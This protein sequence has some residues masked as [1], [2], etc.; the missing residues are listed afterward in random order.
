METVRAASDE[1]REIHLKDYLGVMRKHVWVLLAFFTITEGLAAFYVSRQVP[2]YRASARIQIDRES[3]RVL[4]IPEVVEPDRGFYGDEYYQTQYQ[5]LRSRSLVLEVARRLGL[6]RDPDFLA[7][8]AAGAADAGRA[9]ATVTSGEAAETMLINRM[10]GMVSIDPIKNTRLVDIT[11][12]STKPSTAA[13]VSNAMA[14]AFIERNQELRLNTTRQAT[15]WLGTQLEDARKKVEESETALQR[16][17]EE[18]DI[19]SPEKNVNL[20]GQKLEELSTALTKAKTDRIALETRY[21]Q[22][23]RMGSTQEMLDSLP[24]V[25]GNQLI[26]QMKREYAQLQGELSTLSKTYTPK[27]PKIISLRSQIESLESR[28]RA[29]VAKVTASIRNE[30]EVAKAREESIQEAVDQQKQ[31]AQGLSQKSIQLGA[32][33]REVENNRRIYGILLNRAKE[34]GLAEGIQAGNIRIIDRAEVPLAPFSPRR[35]R[36]MALAVLFGLLGGVALAFFLE[37][38]DDSI[39][40]PDDLERYTRLPFLAPVPIIRTRDKSTP[41]ELVAHKEPKSS[42]AEAYRSARTG[43]MFSSPDAPPVAILVTSSGPEEGKTTTAINLAVTMAHAG[44]RVLVLD[45]D[46]RKPRVHQVFGLKNG[47]GLTNLLTESTDLSAAVHKTPVQ[48]LAVMTSG[49][50]PPNPSELLGSQRMAKLLETLRGSFEKVVVDCPPI[51]S[52]TDASILA[53]YLDG[54]V[55]VVKSGQTSRQIVRRAKKKLEEVRARIIGVVLNSVNV[56][57]S[58]YYYSPVYYY[59]YY[60]EDRGRSRKRKKA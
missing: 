38:L 33:E 48:N 20:V 22:M 34:T 32:L 55:L 36:A 35:F 58:R 18:H 2:L 59:S 60:G 49:P 21:R 19:V 9:G 30:Y 3:P 25:L 10:L 1:A 14:A 24:E 56:R 13:E 50:I 12:V 8:A 41:R 6:D 15:D 27:H 40:D 57:K 26:Q 46:L 39:K 42:Y 43:I 29:E 5:L 4:N 31:V 54:V 51:I 23:Q 53:A 52:V 37:Y 45:A 7:P 17:K 11:T 44:N 28:L 47:F 16:Y